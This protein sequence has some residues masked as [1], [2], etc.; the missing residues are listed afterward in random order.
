MN[1]RLRAVL[2][3]GGFVAGASVIAVQSNRS[4][5]ATTAAVPIFAPATVGFESV[6]AAPATRLWSGCVTAA[7][8]ARR[9]AGAAPLQLD[10]RVAIAS[11][12]H[13]EYQ[14]QT[15][16]LSHTGSAGSNAGDR[17]RAAGYSWATWGENVAAGQANCESVLAGWL[18]SASH[19][20]NI[21]NP[22]F[23]HVGFGMAFGANGVPYWT[24]DLAAGG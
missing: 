14:A 8:V 15:Q 11:A 23:R 16:K 10:L 13:S 19:R 3:V 1:R 24:M 7:N 9:A 18:A 20:A 22:A 6:P 12:G 21:L 17:L 5:G 4:V 2:L